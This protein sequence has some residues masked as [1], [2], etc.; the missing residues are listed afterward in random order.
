[1]PSDRYEERKPF[2]D[3]VFENG[4]DQYVHPTGVTGVKIVTGVEESFLDPY[5]NS[6]YG[7]RAKSS[8]D[9]SIFLADSEQTAKA[10]V[11]QGQQSSGYPPNSW[12]L[13][14]EY[15]GQILNIQ[16]IEDE[17]FKND[18]LEASGEYKHE[19]SQDARHYLDEKGYA[20]KFDSIGWVSV[21]GNQ[22]GQGGFVYNWV[23][24]ESPTFNHLCTIRLDSPSGDQ[25]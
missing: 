2:F 23:S 20:Q 10:E 1:M 13:S 17:N 22:I 5:F 16:K 8:G 7:Q 3:C 12:L 18:F 6:P 21:Q 19:F 24:G 9:L 14:Y 15:Q 11:F 4:V 25:Q